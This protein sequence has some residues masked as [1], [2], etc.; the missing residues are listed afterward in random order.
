MAKLRLTHI[1]P[2]LVIVTICLHLLL[3]NLTLVSGQDDVSKKD[4][5]LKPKKATIEKK[6]DPK[7]P[8]PKLSI[9]GK[10]SD[11]PEI[12]TE[13][14]DDDEFG[15]N[16]YWKLENNTVH[17]NFTYVDKVDD[18]RYFISKT[19]V[20]PTR[21]MN[22]WV[23]IDKLPKHQ[24]FLHEVLSDSHRRAASIV[25]PFMFPFY[26]QNIT[27]ATIA[28]GGFLYM[29]EHVH[30]W[31]AATQYIA[32]LM[33]NFDTRNSTTSAVHYGYNESLF[34]IEWRN[35]RLQEDLSAEFT[36]QCILFRTGDIAFVYKDIPMEIGQIPDSGHPVKIG[37]SDAYFINRAH[38]YVRRKTIYEY[39]KLDLINSTSD[40]I[41]NKTAIYLQAKPTC[42]TLMTCDECLT[43]Q[44]G[45]DCAWCTAVGRCSDGY[46]RKRQEWVSNHCDTH[47]I[48]KAPQCSAIESTSTVHTPV[49]EHSTISSTPSSTLHNVTEHNSVIRT[50]TTN[51]KSVDVHGDKNTIQVEYNTQEKRIGGSSGIGNNGSKMKKAQGG[52]GIA[53][54]LFFL[55]SIVSGMGLWLFYAYRN[56]TS[57]SGQLLIRW[58]PTSWR[59]KSAETRYT[60]ASIHM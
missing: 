56:P 42:I 57:S 9:N 35:V 49:S 44:I 33:A 5:S 2:K 48:D 12:P 15:K 40:L 59:W 24:T 34:V 32:P 14:I 31:L 21:A 29:G 53:L 23:D 30:S 28:T 52:S 46:D 37:V 4:F 3:L 22:L 39:H 20:D 10:G 36:F 1:Q 50:D 51:E 45:F 25:L 43:R 27:R 19:I 8:K 55:L 60:A 47:N 18:Q 58:R 6:S 26:G 54:S 11:G 41:S 16:D 13:F 17:D 38:V 7:N